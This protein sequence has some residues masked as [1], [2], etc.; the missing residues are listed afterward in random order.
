MSLVLIHMT[1]IACFNLNIMEILLNH[2]TWFYES[3]SNIY[4]SL[5]SNQTPVHT[6]TRMICESLNKV[7]T[8]ISSVNLLS[9]YN[10]AF[11]ILSMSVEMNEKWM[12]FWGLYKNDFVKLLIKV[13]EIR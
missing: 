2:I 3:S 6:N 4:K 11:V 10:E 12:K 1:P 13:I 5:V 9:T 8:T 7:I